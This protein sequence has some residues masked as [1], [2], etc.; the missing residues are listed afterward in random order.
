MLMYIVMNFKSQL[1]ACFV[2]WDMPSEDSAELEAPQQSI[3][4]KTKIGMFQPYY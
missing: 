3:E 4:P 2:F 1:I